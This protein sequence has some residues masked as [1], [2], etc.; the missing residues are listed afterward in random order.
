MPRWGKVL[1]VLCALLALVAGPVVVTSGVLAYRFNDLIGRDDVLADAAALPPI[2]A[3]PEYQSWIRKSARSSSVDLPAAAGH[4]RNFL[5][6][7]VDTRKGW[8]AAQSRSDTIMLVHVD[9]DGS[10][11]SVVSIPRDS[12]VYIPPVA[13][14]W[15]G[16][17]T[18]INA[19]YAWG[20]AP[21]MVQV[22]SHLT[23]V[24][25]DNVVRVDFAGVR[26]I[27]DVVGGVDVRVA[28]T[29]RDK[30]TGVTFRAGRHHLDGRMAEVY[31]RQRYGLPNGDFD[32]VKRQQQYLRALAEK[33][34][35]LGVLAHPLKMDEFVTAI[36]GS[37][38]VDSG[39][40]L[41]GVARDLSG[42]RPDDLSF[43]TL[44]SDG[45]VRS[46][47]GTANRLVPEA[48]GELFAALLTDT[49]DA[50]FAKNGSFAGSSGA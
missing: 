28:R 29:V 15:A 49:M 13:G 38:V 45:Y 46:A 12:Y 11:A 25:I 1:T 10:D 9:G 35:S 5:V 48:C 4:A 14:K 34:T 16:G 20:G 43:T 23:G 24:T 50:Y 36:A 31:V 27:T 18:K 47:A 30:R 2:T 42:L 17:K 39:M 32:R 7:G 22:V 3:P 6:L 26:R 37:L 44:P 33:V 40:N 21:L 8:T 19:A 41:A